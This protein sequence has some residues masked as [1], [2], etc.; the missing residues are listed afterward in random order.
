VREILAL[1]G[2]RLIAD[3]EHAGD[4]CERELRA[5]ILALGP[6][7]PT[8]TQAPPSTPA[9]AGSEASTAAAPAGSR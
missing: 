8:A 2:E 6:P 3:L 9:S 5:S 7:P 4:Q 1:D